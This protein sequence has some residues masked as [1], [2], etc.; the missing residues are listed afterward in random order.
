M[1]R[2]PENANNP[3]PVLSTVGKNV[4]GHFTRRPK[5]TTMDCLHAPMAFWTPKMTKKFK[6][7]GLFGK[8]KDSSVHE[9]MNGLAEYLRYRDIDVVIGEEEITETVIL[10]AQALKKV[11]I[12]EL[13]LAD[14][15]KIN[16]CQMYLYFFQRQFQSIVLPKT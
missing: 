7:I 5:S 16:S 12:L 2:S 3:A 4:P 1:A 14:T 10:T 8:Y 11:K 15:M 13:E 6:T 9:A